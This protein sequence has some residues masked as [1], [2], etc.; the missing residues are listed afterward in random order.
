MLASKLHFRSGINSRT[1]LLSACCYLQ[2]RAGHAPP[3]PATY[4]RLHACMPW[5][6]ERRA[7][8]S[9]HTACGLVWRPTGSASCMQGS[10]CSWCLG[11]WG[12]STT[13][14][15][16]ACKD[17][18][19][20]GTNSYCCQ[21]CCTCL[22]PI[23]IRLR[24]RHCL[25]CSG[26]GCGCCVAGR[27]CHVSVWQAWLGGRLAQ[28]AR[29]LALQL[30]HLHPTAQQAAARHITSQGRHVTLCPGCSGHGS[31]ACAVCAPPHPPS[32]SGHA[33]S[34]G[35]DQQARASYEM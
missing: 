31:T 4:S 27:R 33:R 3:G 1:T 17:E 20:G 26:C 34:K 23:A 30:L 21:V 15:N 7:Q 5:R 10:S 14:H 32:Q 19:C 2:G 28:H 13:T 16:E 9:F 8:A 18:A 25:A 22:V 35:C 6:H 12:L 24:R 11:A 29:R